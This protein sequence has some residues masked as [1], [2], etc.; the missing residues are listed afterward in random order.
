[1]RITGIALQVLGNTIGG[2]AFFGLSAGG[3]QKLVT[4]VGLNQEALSGLGLLSI[5]GML[6]WKAGS[7]IA[8]PQQK[9]MSSVASAAQ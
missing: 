9:M 7:R 8:A 6:L 3:L 1:M 5:G 2:V 4:A